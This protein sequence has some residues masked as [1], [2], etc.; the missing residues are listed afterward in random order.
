MK[1]LKYFMVTLLETAGLHLRE[2]SELDWEHFYFH[3][4]V[5][6]MNTQNTV[7]SLTAKDGMSFIQLLF[8]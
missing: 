5:E 1:I 3:L 6:A 4:F 7:W 2:G 8:F